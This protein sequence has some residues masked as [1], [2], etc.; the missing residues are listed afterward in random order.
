LQP[1]N[2]DDVKGDGKLPLGFSG[3]REA[4]QVLLGRSQAPALSTQTGP[5][6]QDSGTPLDSGTILERTAMVLEVQ[7]PTTCRLHLHPGGCQDQIL[8]HPLFLPHPNGGLLP[9]PSDLPPATPCYHPELQPPEQMATTPPA[10]W[11][12]APGQHWQLPVLAHMSPKLS[13][14]QTYTPQ[15]EEGQRCS[16]EVS[17]WTQACMVV[18]N[19]LA[20]LTTRGLTMAGTRVLVS[21]RGLQG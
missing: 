13:S 10:P 5:A 11:S 20:H 4:D 17:C 18:G 21:T 19:H 16:K 7:T 6:S 15:P 3:P 1:L 12:N 14:C 9:L 2:C 8:N